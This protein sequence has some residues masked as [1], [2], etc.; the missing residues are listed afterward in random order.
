M[1]PNVRH[2]DEL[3][4][5]P[6]N[7]TEMNIGDIAICR[8]PAYLFAHRVIDKGVEDG[9]RPHI[10]TR[11]DRNRVGSDGKTYD[12]NLLGRVAR[13]ER[14]GM[15][16]SILPEKHPLPVHL[17]HEA[18]L[19]FTNLSW[20]A[21]ARLRELLLP[22]QSLPAYRLFGNIWWR[23]SVGRAEYSIRIP[24]HPERK[25]TFFKK[26]EIGE[27]GRSY[28]DPEGASPVDLFMLDLKF[29][30][31]RHPACTLTL[32]RSPD[33]CIKKGWWADSEVRFRYRGTG[34]EDAMIEKA[35]G[36]I[37]KYGQAIYCID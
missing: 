34:I 19:S 28:L 5:E 36:I 2:G 20:R 33:G 25:T 6:A 21:K 27:F 4:I 16:V 12:E 37:G 14:N 18:R 3:V 17:F 32:T 8:K 31:G 23:L 11:A 15:Q 7:A 26:I 9:G 13:I 24:L 1:Y 22:V 10:V 29:K 35:A 30:G